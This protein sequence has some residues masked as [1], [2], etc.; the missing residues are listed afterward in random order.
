ME[1]FRVGDFLTFRRKTLIRG[2]KQWDLKLMSRSLREVCISFALGGVP[3]ILSSDT[4]D[5]FKKMLDLLLTAPELLNYY[6]V[7]LLIFGMSAV[8]QFKWRFNSQ[9][10]QE[11]L[12][13][14]HRFL[15]EIGSC[16]LTAGRT[17]LGA[18]IGFISVWWW[19]EPSSIDVF[20]LV[21]TLV[22]VSFLLFF[23]VFLSIGEDALKN[24]RQA[25]AIKR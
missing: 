8:I 12:F 11:N 23:C 16:F 15:A 3:V 1:A 14:L 6:A 13:R 2:R 10:H 9:R 19:V 17:G 18:I 4:S 22:Y 21:K 20:N 24:P 7:L 5:N 25:A